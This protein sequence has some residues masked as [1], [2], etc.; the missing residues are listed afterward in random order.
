MTARRESPEEAAIRLAESAPPLSPEQSARLATLLTAANAELN[1][2]GLVQ[3]G[4]DGLD[5]DH[6]A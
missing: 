2:S 4:R 5:L 6:V 1:A 3:A